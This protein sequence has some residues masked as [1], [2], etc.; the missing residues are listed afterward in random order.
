M[1]IVADESIPYLDAALPRLGEAVR[2]PAETLPDAVR[3]ADAVVVRSVTRVDEGLLAGS[4]VRVV[5]SATT[6]LDHI[7][8]EYL[9]RNGIALVDAAGANATAVAE[10]VAA[11]L[12]RICLE[13]GRSPGELALG[14]VGL[15]RI[16][17][18]VAR[19]AGALGMR[20]VAYDPPLGRATAEP[21]F[22]P[23]DEVQAC[24]VVTLHVPLTRDGPDPTYHLVDTSFLDAFDAGTWLVNT[25]RG[26]VVNNVAVREALDRNALGGFVCDVWEREPLPMSEL[27]R[28]CRIATPHVAGHSVDAKVGAAQ[29]IVE[30][31]ART[32]GVDAA[33]SEK[34]LAGTAPP[35]IVLGQATLSS[36]VYAVETATEI[37]RFDAAL[38]ELVALAPPLRGARF[39]QV[40]SAPSTRRAFAAHC[41]EIPVDSD[42]AWAGTLRALGFEVAEY[43]SVAMPKTGGN[44]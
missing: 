24:D 37:P 10:Y 18:R 22:R 40:R 32:L 36:L 42:A 13:T 8:T 2:V 23:L 7:D 21:V 44:S 26:A 41:V 35:A 28:Q 4:P 25:S 27:V 6:G 31:L 11:A 9:R 34:N 14:I 39:A 19:Y 29:R 12:L 38:R 3:E 20:C 16:G 30:G 1:R 43:T 33:G 15:G 17:A 5:G